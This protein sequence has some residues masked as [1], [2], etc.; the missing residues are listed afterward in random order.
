[1]GCSLAQGAVKASLSARH[2]SRRPTFGS[3]SAQESAWRE[4]HRRMDNGTQIRAVATLAMR[5][6]ASVDRCGY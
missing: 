4:D 6:P 2:R 1:M 5:A 3:G